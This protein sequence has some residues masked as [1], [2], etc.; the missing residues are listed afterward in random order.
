MKIDIE[1]NAAL[2]ETEVLI[3]CRKADERIASIVSS[4]QMHDLR[5]AGK[6]DGGTVSVPAGALLYIECVDGRTFA[7]T[8][9][10][11][12]ELSLRLHELE[13][14]LEG[15]SFVRIA[16]NCL[17]NICR[18]RSLRPYVG[19]RLLATM[20]NGEEIVVSRRYAKQ[21]KTVLGIGRE[22]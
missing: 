19:A 11:V 1:E 14:R 12:L 7:Y 3:R 16:K 4:L 15:A 6:S 21:L 10:A 18:I 13:D 17:A 9:D 22:A 20:D 2:R 5:V 8:Q